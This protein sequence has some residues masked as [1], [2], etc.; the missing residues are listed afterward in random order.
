MGQGTTIAA[1]CRLDAPKVRQVGSGEGV[2][3]A[4]CARSTAAAHAAQDPMHTRIPAFH[5]Q[6]K[7]IQASTIENGYRINV[8]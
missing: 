3:R 1:H 6:L 4:V 8:T 5:A 2:A 7:G